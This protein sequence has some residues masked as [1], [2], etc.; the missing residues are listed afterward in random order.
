M[1]HVYKSVC[2]REMQILQVYPHYFSFKIAGLQK[3]DVCVY[4]CV[5]YFFSI[6]VIYFTS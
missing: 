1:L 6:A 4:V 5:L 2:E 3:A